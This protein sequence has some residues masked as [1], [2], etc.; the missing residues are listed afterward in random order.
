MFER[1]GIAQATPG[2]VLRMLVSLG[3]AL[4]LWGWVTVQRDPLEERTLA[5]VEIAPLELADALMEVDQ[6]DPVEVEVEGPRSQVEDL[7]AEDLQARLE[8]DEIT[9]PGTYSAHVDVD[10][11]GAVDVIRVTPSNVDVLVDERLTELVPIE[12]IEPNQSGSERR[13]GEV[14]ID[15]PEVRVSGP[16]QSME[17]ITRVAVEI[18]LGNQTSDFRTIL[19][20]VALDAENDPVASVLISPETV[21]V[22]VELIT[23]GKSVPVFVRTSG[24]P[25]HEYEVTDRRVTPQ[26]VLLAGPEDALEE[27]I[28]VT[29]DPVD[30]AGATRPISVRTTIAGLP[31]G[32]RVIDPANGIVQ[33]DI[34]VQQQGERQTL[35]PLNVEVIGI[36]EGLQATVEPAAVT[37]T[38]IG[39]QD[40]ITALRA[41]DI[42]P[43][44]DVSGMGAGT[45]SLEPSVRVPR[46]LRW[47]AVDPV[48][49][50]VTL[51]PLAAETPEPARTPTPPPRP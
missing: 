19:T 48:L 34:G 5:A 9:G 32:V 50:E 15:P 26:N 17:Q 11:P 42:M 35:P 51:T 49:V 28:S 41:D 29:T 18:E 7:T 36:G 46:G 40:A 8:T 23:E 3:L 2:P 25:A 47:E 31:N 30:I 37:I 20:P 22:D 1:F 6:L 14:R 27:I 43:Q 21:A 39:S 33:V 45:Y 13:I 16:Q 38:V 12:V 10:A 44:V 4:L 24:E